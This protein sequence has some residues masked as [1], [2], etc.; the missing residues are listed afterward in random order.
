M[1]ETSASL[2]ERLRRPTD[3]E[4]WV[5]FT[6]L[7]TP[8][9]F[10]W[11]RRIGLRQEDAADLVQDVLTM[12]IRELPRFAYEP[13]GSFRGWLRTVTLNRWRNARRKRSESLLA[14][15]PGGEV[16]TAMPDHVPEIVEADYRRYLVGRALELMKASFRPS[17]WKACWE[18]VVLDRPAADVA[19]E[20]G[21]SEG[22]VYIA[23]SRVLARL[24]EELRGLL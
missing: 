9:L 13:S 1:D 10:H 6:Q 12:L 23:T 4:A 24:R 17:T 7:Y 22:A 16:E 21:I 20:L 2:L 11:A 19:V 8:L 5:R 3:A 14:A 18:H 15:A